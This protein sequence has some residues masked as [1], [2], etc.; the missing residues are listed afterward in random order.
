MSEN[1]NISELIE[2]KS[3]PNELF[4]LNEIFDPPLYEIYFERIC[5]ISKLSNLNP[6]KNK[7]V[8]RYNLEIGESKRKNKILLSIISSGELNYQGIIKEIKT[9]TKFEDNKLIIDL[10]KCSFTLEKII[11]SKKEIKEIL[12]KSKFEINII[13]PPKKV[14]PLEK[15]HFDITIINN[16]INDKNISNKYK[17]EKIKELNIIKP[18]LKKEKEV[19]KNSQK[20]HLLFNE[21]SSINDRNKK[22]SIDKISE[23]D[24]EESIGN[25]S[26]REENNISIMINPN[27]S[28]E[29]KDYYYLHQEDYVKRKLEHLN[30]ACSERNIYSDQIYVL[31]E[32]NKFVKKYIML[33]PNHFCII[34]QNTLKFEYVEKIKNIEK[35]VISNKNLNMILFK[36]SIGEDLLIES[37]RANDLIA[38]MKK[39]YFS[40][41]GSTFRY[42]DQFIIKL[43]GQLHRHNATDKILTDLP[44]FDGAIKFGYLSLYKPRLISSNFT[45]TIGVLTN[46]GLL[47]LEESSLR[48]IQ[49][50]PILESKIKKV[51]NKSLEIILPSGISNLFQFRKPRERDEWMQQFSK[52]KNDY[53]EKMK[54]IWRN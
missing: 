19:E 31:V 25:I 34:N 27:I 12:I 22:L 33:S 50:I 10:P 42:K 13:S 17:I 53:N 51:N 38:Y 7:I 15:S 35:I 16:I 44:N 5:L 26:T 8:K 54:L 30:E 6:K 9:K 18:I 41:K 32:K 47:L 29:N 23:I 52:M 40:N 36:F 37:L 2:K 39:N 14:K 28:F 43:K 21:D 1:P 4:N 49:L 48:P 45:E 24:L 20:I 3:D 46:I 11:P